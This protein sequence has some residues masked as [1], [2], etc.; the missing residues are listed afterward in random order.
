[1]SS[2]LSTE[3]KARKIRVNVVSPGTIDTAR[4][5]WAAQPRREGPERAL[6][7]GDPARPAWPHRGDRERGIVP[8]IGREQLRHGSRIVRRWRHGT[9]MTLPRGPRGSPGQVGRSFPHVPA[10]VAVAW[11]EDTLTGI[12]AIR[13]LH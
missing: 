4:S 3:L 13:L 12:M 5:A 9:G 10:D 8:R 7:G 2:R 1:M 6:R 11:T